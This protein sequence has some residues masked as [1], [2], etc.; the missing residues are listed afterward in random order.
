MFADCLDTPKMGT[1]RMPHISAADKGAEEAREGAGGAE[2]G[3]EVSGGDVWR[4]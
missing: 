2:K 4:C 3:G 1:W